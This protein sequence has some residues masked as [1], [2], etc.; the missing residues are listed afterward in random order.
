M[1]LKYLELSFS[2]F[3]S[4]GIKFTF[5]SLKD[6]FAAYEKEENMQKKST[7]IRSRNGSLKSS[8]KNT[9]GL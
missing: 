5:K 4:R 1:P 9:L 7:V 6:L 8:K 2:D 3:G